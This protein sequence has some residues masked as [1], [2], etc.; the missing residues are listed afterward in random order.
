MA[1]VLRV[2]G[3]DAAHL[4]LG[5]V[6]H[7]SAEADAAARDVAVDGLHEVQQRQQRRALLRV[8]RD[9]LGGVDV[10]LLEDVGGIGRLR[11][12]ADVQVA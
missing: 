6:E 11:L 5:E 12:R 7:L 9:D 3:G 10:Q 8:A 2:E 4:G 1:L